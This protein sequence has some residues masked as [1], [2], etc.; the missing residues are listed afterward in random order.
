MLSASDGFSS[1]FGARKSFSPKRLFTDAG[2]GVVWEFP[3]TLPLYTDEA[4]ATPLTTPA[5]TVGLVKDGSRVRSPITAYAG[6]QASAGLRPSWGV[7]PL[8]RRQLL[9]YSDNFA[10]PGWAASTGGTGSLPAITA[11]FGVAPDGTTTAARVQLDKGAGATSSDISQWAGPNIA[12][13]VSAS[14]TYGVWL[15][16]NDGSTK[17][18]TLVNPA[19]SAQLITV[20]G[21]WQQFSVSAVASAT[22]N[23]PRIRLRGTEGTANAADILFW[24]PQWEPGTVPTA[25]QKS[26]TTFEITEPGFASYGYI[27]PDRSDDVLSTV[28]TLA[29]T[30][31]VMVFGRN[32]SW[33]EEARVY[34]AG[35]TFSL[36]ASGGVGPGASQITGFTTLNILAALGDIVGIV[37]IGRTLTA[38]ERASTLAYFRAR[39][40]AG[41][42]AVSGAELVSNGT[43]DTVTTGWTAGANTTLSVVAAALRITATANGANS[44][45]TSF[46]TVIGQPYLLS[47]TFVAD[48]MTGGANINVGTVA[49]GTTNLNVFPGNVVGTY[50]ATFVATAATTFVTLSGDASA[51]ATQTMDWDNVSCK[52]LVAS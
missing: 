16:T 50:T 3:T 34:G 14:F 41:M 25:Y 12:Q 4:G 31:D 21:S 26:V 18:V 1:P 40:A 52:L 11:N 13:I 37:A 47:A 7:A 15:K 39:G 32:G 27:R 6:V 23:F 48:A 49:G 36:G 33:I 24:H 30:G 38:A 10:N 29:Q 28:L 42:L 9:P 2:N 44:G 5:Q 46:A 35:A 20:T 43:F 8:S 22:T 19:S 17:A 51:L 45:S